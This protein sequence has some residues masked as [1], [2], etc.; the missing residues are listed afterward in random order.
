LGYQSCASLFE[1]KVLVPGTNTQTDKTINRR[2][3][4]SRAKGQFPL[5]IWKINR[6]HQYQT[7]KAA[8]ASSS[9]NRT[10]A[11]VC[12]SPHNRKIL[13]TSQIPPLTAIY[14]GPGGDAN[15]DSVLHHFMAEYRRSPLHAVRL[16]TSHSNIVTL[17]GR[18]MMNILLI[19]VAVLI[20]Q[21]KVALLRRIHCQR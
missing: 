4:T 9:A 19:I 16:N 7:V 6:S 8:P 12:H 17:K 5:D 13:A 1:K 15:S 21:R 18:F 2:I 10:Q 20:L 11:L 14:N 3:L